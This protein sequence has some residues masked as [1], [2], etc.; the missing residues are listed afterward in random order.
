MH[1][2]HVRHMLR[3]EAKYA[4]ELPVVHSRRDHWNQHY[5]QPCRRAVFYRRE[6]L[7]EQ[8]APSERYVNLVRQPVK[9]QEDGAQSRRLEL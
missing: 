6:L 1:A 5:A 2:P 9:L 7:P 3:R 4:A 8:R